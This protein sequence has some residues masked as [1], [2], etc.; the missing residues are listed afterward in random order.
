MNPHD[1]MK[2]LV[3]D[4]WRHLETPGDTWGQTEKTMTIENN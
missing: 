4:T 1:H 2:Q 3:R